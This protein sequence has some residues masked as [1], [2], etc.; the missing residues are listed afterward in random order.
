MSGIRKVMKG[1]FAPWLVLLCLAPPLSAGGADPFH[2]KTRHPLITVFGLPETQGPSIAN[3]GHADIRLNFD[4][5]NTYIRDAN[6]RER[7]MIDMEGHYVTLSGRYGIARQ[8]ETGADLPL[9]ILGGG[10]LDGLIED[11]HTT[12]GF[13][14]GG[15]KSDPRNRLLFRYQRNGLVRSALDGSSSGIGDIRL[16]G[17]WQI[18][19]S[20]GHPL[21]PRLTLRTSLKLPTGNAR[22][23]TGSGS[24]DLAFWLSADTALPI[25]SGRWRAYLEGGALFMTR[26]NILP[27]Q[28]RPVVGFGTLGLAMSPASW[29]DFKAQINAHTPFFSKSDLNFLNA[30]CVQFTF[31]G[32]WHL[33]ERITLTVGIMEDLTVETS[34]DAVI[35]SGLQYKF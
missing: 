17:A 29:I 11:F 23:L 3:E 31:G 18:V 12:F 10:F 24:M 9:V 15:R 1:F 13:P 5:A 26:G 4:L 20:S 35:H 32:S 7:L 34:P 19:S 22:S 28:Q 14:D 16:A 2:T 27:D 33:S 6:L 21:Q 8:I 30:S 25:P